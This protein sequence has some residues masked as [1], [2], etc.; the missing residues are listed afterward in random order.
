[1]SGRPSMSCVDRPSWWNGWYQNSCY[2]TS[3]AAYRFF[4]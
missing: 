1:M 3:P 2:A 4:R